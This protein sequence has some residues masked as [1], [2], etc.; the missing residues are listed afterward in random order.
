MTSFLYCLAIIIVLCVSK[1][2]KMGELNAIIYDTDEVMETPFP[3][4]SVWHLL[5][6]CQEKQSIQSCEMLQKT[7]YPKNIFIK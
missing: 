6:V 1:G 3:D 4:L 2:Y 7:Y 5:T